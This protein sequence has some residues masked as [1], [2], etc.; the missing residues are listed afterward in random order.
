MKKIVSLIFVMLL[1]LSLFAEERNALLIANGKYQSFSS[2]ATPAS[3]AR[4]LKKSLEKLGFKVTI[5]ENGGKEKM[6]DALYDFQQVLQKAGGIGFFHYGGHAVQV[7]GKNYLIPVDADIPDERR[8]ATRAIDVEE[9]MTSMQGDTNIVILD[10]CRNNPLPAGSGRSATRGLTLVT[11]KPKNSIIVYSAEPGKVAQDGVFTP[12]LAQKLLEQKSFSDIL[13][14]VRKE[15]QSRTNSEQS[16]EEWGRL[17]ENIYLAGLAA[18]NNAPAKVETKTIVETVVETKVIVTD[19][20]SPFEIAANFHKNNTKGS[21]S[22]TNEQID[23]EGKSYTSLCIQGNTGKV[24]IDG[25][26]YWNAANWGLQEEEDQALLNFLTK[27]ETIKFKVIGDGKYWDLAFG[28]HDSRTSYSYRFQPKKNK[29]TEITIPY[30]KF[31]HDSWT[32]NIK[33]FKY[34]INAI[35]IRAVCEE[36]SDQQRKLQIF[37]VRVY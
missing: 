21:M 27:G 9:V 20:T 18:Q 3:E 5:I 8:I 11:E 14:D 32:E 24:K 34:E 22:I 19:E 26:D 33:F 36:G 1:V 25:S 13:I 2:L 6:S 7:N 4:D 29:I 17:T 16:P 35:E 12:I 10:S 30:K 15:V 23:Y 28:M 37:D 31:V